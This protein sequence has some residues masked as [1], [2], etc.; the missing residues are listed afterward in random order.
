MPEAQLTEPLVL[1]AASTATWAASTA[2]ATSPRRSARPPAPAAWR[3]R[4]RRFPTTAAPPPSG[5]PNRAARAHRRSCPADQRRYRA[6]RRAPAP[7]MYLGRRTG[8]RCP[9]D[10]GRR[11]KQP[12]GSAKTR[13]V[14]PPCGRRRA[15]HT[16]PPRA[17]PRVGQLA[18]VE[19]LRHRPAAGRL[20]TTGLSRGNTARFRLCG[21]ARRHRRRRRVDLESGRRAAIEIVDIYHAKQHHRTDLAT[22]GPGTGVP[23]WTPA[24][25][26]PSSP[27]C[28]SMSRP[29]PRRESAFTTC[30]GTATGCAIR[31]SAPGACASRR[32]SRGRMQADRRPAQARRHA[33]RRRGQRHHRPA[34]HPQ[35]TLRG[36]LGAASR[37]RRLTLI[38]Q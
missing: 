25:C 5:T 37:K 38:S 15:R 27:R 34:L 8:C 7:T 1:P 32:A 29:R 10:E 35:R 4:G 18:A 26:A 2:G 11:R 16:R 19:S 21:P 17:G 33:H 9:T 24:G 22:G 3:A 30:S 14:E 23:N 20:R 28:A 6:A 12:D 31:S 13:E 36:L